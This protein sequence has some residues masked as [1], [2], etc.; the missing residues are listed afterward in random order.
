MIEIYRRPLA[1][2]T[3][4]FPCAFSP[5][6][7]EAPSSAVVWIERFGITTEHAATLQPGATTTA[8]TVTF[9]P[10]AVFV[11]PGKYTLTVRFKN[12]GGATIARTV[13]QTINALNY[14]SEPT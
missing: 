11:E 5:A 1:Y 14:P 7:S 2:E 12:A 6:L 13:P 4:Q 8:A 10:D 9:V 3:L